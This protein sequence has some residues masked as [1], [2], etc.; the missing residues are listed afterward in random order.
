MRKWLVVIGM[1]VAVLALV[2]LVRGARQAPLPEPVP[3]PQA[4]TPAPA[5]AA[6]PHGPDAG[7]AGPGSPAA[8]PAAGD[9]AG[10]MAAMHQQPPDENSR[11]MRSYPITMQRLE[12]YVATVKQIRASGERD[13]SLLTQL[14]QPRPQGEQPSGMAARLEAIAPLKRI[15]DEHGLAGIDLVILPQ[16]V[17][18]GRNAYALEQEGRP[19]PAAEV[20]AAALALYRADLPKVDALTKLFMADLKVVSGR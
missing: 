2:L 9:T 11:L 8:G 14:R 1:A 12:T 19:L 3:A 10:D 4:S 6:A 7:G 15:L 16:V 17:F 20:N 5:A 18:A 13:R